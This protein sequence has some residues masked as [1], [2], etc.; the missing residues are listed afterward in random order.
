MKKTIHTVLT[1]AAFAAASM[2]AMPASAGEGNPSA[3]PDV[4]NKVEKDAYA[5]FYGAYGPPPTT[6]LSET[7]TTTSLSL[8]MTT[9]TTTTTTMPQTV[10]GPATT[11]N[12][13]STY[14]E[15][16]VDM[17]TTM[18]PQPAY[19]PAPVYLGD[20]NMDGVVDIFDAVAVRKAILFDEYADKINRYFADLNKD[21]NI[22]V[23]DLV[24]LNRYLLGSIKDLEN[25]P[26]RGDDVIVTTT[27]D[28]KYD[29]IDG[30]V[31]LYDP[32]TDTVV[33]V[34]GPPS[35]F[36]TKTYG[37]T[38]DISQTQPDVNKMISEEK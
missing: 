11:F 8:P 28:E 9:L 29:D 35:V 3:F 26:N 4:R 1:A 25:L 21:G 32:R 10:Y 5:E 16:V 6:S 24:L 34:Y 38:A 2:S 7:V 20:A 37:T 14:Q 15:D 12:V 36:F 22:T 18:L 30:E 31:T 33:P 13:I 17:T 19:G 23:G 27:T